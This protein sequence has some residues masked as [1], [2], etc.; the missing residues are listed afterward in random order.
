MSPDIHTTYRAILLILSIGLVISG[1][2]DLKTW[3]VFYSKGLL[4]WKVSKLS[5]KWL[6]KGP[7]SNLLDFLL[8][9][10]VFKDTIF[11]RIIA[12]GLLFLLTILNIISPSLLCMLFFLNI[13]IALRSPYSLDG[14]YQMYLILLAALSIGTTFGINSQV[15]VLSLWF[16]VAELVV[17]YFISGITKLFSPIWRKPYAL[18]VIFSTRTYGHN[19]FYRLIQKSNAITIIASW[20]VFLF[21]TLFFTVLFFPPHY[22]VLFLIVG[23]S[24]H[25]FNAF[26]MGLNNFFFAFLATYPALLYC[27]STIY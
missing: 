19:G 22:T 26:F 15:A 9:D 16:I 23:I 13:L 7:L 5:Y 27:V 1:V 24:F 8:N 10:R 3:S 25:F 12:P 14:A 18:N 17:A 11:L 4:S 2:E 6:A 20:S 21:E